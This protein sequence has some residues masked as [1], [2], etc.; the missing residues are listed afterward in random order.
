MNAEILIQEA[1]DKFYRGT[2]R[3][4]YNYNGG[5]KFKD[6]LIIELGNYYEPLDRLIFLYRIAKNID[7]AYNK[8][9]EKCKHKDE[10]NK[11]QESMFH[12]ECKFFTEQEI[13]ELNPEFD[14]TI[15]RPNINSDLLK[16]NLVELKDFPDASKLYLSALDKLNEEK[17]ERN[18]LDDLRLCLESLLKSVLTNNKS[19]EKQ[20]ESLGKYLKQHN[21]SKEVINMFTTLIDYYSKY[22]NAYIKHDDNVK[23]NEI[24][25]IVNLTSAFI[26]FVI[27]Q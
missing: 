1:A 8:H 11:C 20:F 3:Y 25:L 4:S 19:L 5:Q 9:Q 27:N 2:E 13:R 21:A 10:P 22:H 14:Y 7:T 24:E 6:E 23:K 16:Q 15:V 26:N 18:L 12:L 17:F